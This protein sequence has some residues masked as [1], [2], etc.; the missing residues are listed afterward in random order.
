MQAFPQAR[1]MPQEPAN[2]G[3]RMPGACRRHPPTRHQRTS[4]SRA[5][6]AWDLGS[7][8]A[9]I[10]RISGTPGPKPTG[11]LG[12]SSGWGPSQMGDQAF[13]A[14]GAQVSRVIWMFPAARSKPDV[15]ARHFQLPGSKA[16]RVT[17]RFPAAQIQAGW[18]IAAF[19]R[20]QKAAKG[21]SCR[22]LLNTCWACR[23]IL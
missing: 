11:N 7:G 3:I 6:A 2:P 13:P 4:R 1:R 23:E 16:R 15:Q 8:R 5:P 19:P 22:V 12:I 14:D 18:A 9:G 20:I 17:E 21:D 10:C